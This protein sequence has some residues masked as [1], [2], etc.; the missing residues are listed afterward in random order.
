MKKTPLLVIFCLFLGA[1]YAV[2]QSGGSP[3]LLQKGKQ[4][5][6]QSH[7]TSALA[8]FRSIIGNSRLATLHGDAYYWSA[9]S[10]IALN[11]L[12]EAEKYL[13][14]FLSTYPHNANI[15]DGH[16]QKGR[17]L[18][19]QGQY[20]NAI[21]VLYTF[22][23]AYGKNPFVANAYYWIGESLYQLG[24]FNEAKKV[25]EAVVS[26]YPTSYKVEAARYRLSLI[27]LKQR[28]LDLMKLLRWS[29]E[30]AL[31]AQSD[32]NRK[33]QAYEQ[34]IVAYQRQIA[35]LKSGQKASAP[36]ASGTKV[37]SLEAQIARLEQK[38]K[39]LTAQKRQPQK[40]SQAAANERTARLLALKAQALDLK[41]YYLNQLASHLGAAK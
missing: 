18:Y 12:T 37:S 14:H 26:E 40:S 9:L 36:Q 6:Q 11:K 15:P 31:N 23:K 1:G 34:A 28:E 13:E 5:F 10:Y 29:H 2:A 41:Q 19:L 35:K 3:N 8:D 17:L 16:Y 24:H 39:E 38:V 32:F 20:Q 21:R 22:I 27:D 4:E 25:F 33:E 7:Y 30:Q